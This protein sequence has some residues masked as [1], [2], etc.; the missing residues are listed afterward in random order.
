MT[1]LKVQSQNIDLDYL[2]GAFNQHSAAN[3][4]IM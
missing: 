4:R 1:S 2:K 3:L